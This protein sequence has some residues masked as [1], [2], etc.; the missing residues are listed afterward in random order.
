MA[1]SFTRPLNVLRNR[2]FSMHV[3]VA[4]PSVRPCRWTKPRHAPTTSTPLL[5]LRYHDSITD[6]VA[7]L[8]RPDEIGQTFAGFQKHLYQDA[9]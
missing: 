4:T 1:L 9:S 7:D 8:G 6:A 5:K 3:K 2:L